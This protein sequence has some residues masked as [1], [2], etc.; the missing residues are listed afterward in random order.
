MKLT[1]GDGIGLLGAMLVLNTGKNVANAFSGGRN[2][3]K[4]SFTNSAT[5]RVP[6]FPP[7]CR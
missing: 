2:L 5:F 3:H 4:A 6:I 1:P 7:R